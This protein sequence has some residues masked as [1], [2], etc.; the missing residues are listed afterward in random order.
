MTT[1]HRAIDDK[2]RIFTFARTGDTVAIYY[3]DIGGEHF[4]IGERA[5]TITESFGARPVRRWREELPLARLDDFRRGHRIVDLV[6]ATMTP[7]RYFPRV[8]RGPERPAIDVPA[9][10]ATMRAARSLFTRLRDVF[11]VVEPTRL[12]DAV[13]GHE[14]RQ[15]LMLAST[16]VESSWRAVLTANAYPVGAG[17]WG[18]N[19]YV[20]LLG[21]MKLDEYVTT[22]ASH[23]EYGE[24]APFA[25]WDAASPT[26]SLAW[27]DAYNATKHNRE[28]ELHRATVRAVIHAMAAVHVVTVAQFG[29]DEVERGH[30]HADEFNFE[31]TPTWF[32]DAY[33]R[34]LLLP[35][36]PLTGEG[37]RYVDWPED[38]EKGECP[39]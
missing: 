21:P 20:K 10:T 5:S 14:L 6:D 4:V 29:F 1:W 30:F 27:Y 26:R 9:R 22:L 8:Y 19:D 33:I 28:D 25:G 2:S 7:G 16:E 13:F 17:R 36:Q 23:P 32:S 24:I 35:D 34:P 38:W 37:G 39:F 31:H 3:P 18:T 15:L 11:Q 12:H